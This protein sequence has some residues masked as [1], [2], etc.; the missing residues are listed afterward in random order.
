VLFVGALGKMEME[1]V[2]QAGYAIEGLWISGFQRK[3]G[4]ELFSFPFKLLSSWWKSR[5]ILKRFRPDVVVGVGGYA[6]GVLVKT[7]T[8]AGIPALIHEQNSH[9]GLTN[10]KLA[11]SVQ[12]VCVAYPNMERFFPAAKIVHTGNPIR[13]D[14]VDISQKSA[15]IADYEYFGLDPQLPTLLVLGGSLGARTINQT[16]QQAL[17]LLSKEPIQVLW[18]CGKLYHEQLKDL[19]SPYKNVHLRPFLD[20]MPSAY[21]VADIIVSRA[22]ALSISEICVAGKPAIFIPSPNVTD[23]HQTANARALAD[24]GAAILVKDSEAVQT[25]VPI[26]LDLF[27]QPEKRKNLSENIRTFAV[28]NAAE[29]IAKEV[30]GLIQK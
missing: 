7:A 27:D 1:K 29:H 2:P 20:K 21:A 12:K 24:K 9:A 14:I 17:E 28:A 10:R 16:F 25:L 3:L 13:Q 30:L 19:V 4:W 15:Q 11:Q 5:Q 6:S 18:Q 23:D 22:G 8:W 26:V